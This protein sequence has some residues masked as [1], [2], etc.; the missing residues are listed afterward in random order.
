MAAWYNTE[1][2]SYEE[3]QIYSFVIYF[4]CIIFQEKLNF[5]P[6]LTL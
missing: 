6:I 1:I 3:T 5:D 4:V 2:V